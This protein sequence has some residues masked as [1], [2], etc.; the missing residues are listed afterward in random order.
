MISTIRRIRQGDSNG[1]RADAI[2]VPVWREESTGALTSDVRL[3]EVP[4]FDVVGHGES[5]DVKLRA[6]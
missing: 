2:F 6:N 1:L 3:T 5:W 4:V